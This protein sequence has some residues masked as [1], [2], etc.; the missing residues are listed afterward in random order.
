M[1]LANHKFTKLTL[2]Q[3]STPKFDDEIKLQLD[4]LVNSRQEISNEIEE[5]KK[6]TLLKELA[7]KVI[8]Q[9]KLA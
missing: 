4:E 7:N 6:Q 3:K 9:E 2:S 5:L 8:E 1:K